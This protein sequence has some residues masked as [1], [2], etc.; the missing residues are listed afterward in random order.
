MRLFWLLLWLGGSVICPLAQIARAQVPGTSPTAQIY[1]FGEDG[2]KA[3]VVVRMNHPRY[4]D[5]ACRAKRQGS[6]RLSLVVGVNGRAQN[7]RVSR[8]L[9]F[10]IDEQAIQAIQTWRFMPGMKDGK[11]VPFYGAIEVYYHL[12]L[13]CSPEQG[14][15]ISQLEQDHD[16]VEAAVG[17]PFRTKSK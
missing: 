8:K 16:A 5:A 9:G 6:L 1:H 12:P 11:T 7:I 13:K 4:T 10:G 14:D 17:F 15:E 2:V 3:Q